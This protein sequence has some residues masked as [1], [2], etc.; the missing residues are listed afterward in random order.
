MGPE[1]AR[2]RQTPARSNW[3]SST[4]SYAYPPT[5]TWSTR[6]SIR[7]TTRPA[8]GSSPLPRGRAAP[9]GQFA[10]EQLPDLGKVWAAQER[11]W[12]QRTVL[13]VIAQVNKN[14]KNW[15]SAIV[16]QIDGPRSRQPHGSGPA[17]ARQCRGTQEGGRDPGSRSGVRA[18]RP[19]RRR[20]RWREGWGGGRPRSMM[21]GMGGRA[22]GTMSGGVAGQR[23]FGAKYDDT[24]YY[25][26]PP[27]DKNQYKILPILVTVLIDQDHV[28]DFLVEL[29]NSPMSIQ[30]MDFELARPTSRV[31]KPEKGVMPA[32][33]GMMGMMGGMEMMRGMMGAGQSAYGGDDGPDEQMQMQRMGRRSRWHA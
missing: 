7:S 3:R 30:V 21:G 29:E 27:N 26:T 17:F 18:K 25:I 28:Q 20:C 6:P 11:L 22:A 19:R 14:A 12:I 31:T 16:K 13:D 5:S 24:I 9:A 10:D 2:E 4:T 32:G 8:K 1:M 23:R 33:G 15:D